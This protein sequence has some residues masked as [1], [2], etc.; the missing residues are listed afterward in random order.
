MCG[1]KYYKGRKNLNKCSETGINVY[2][3]VYAGVKNNLQTCGL[4]CNKSV[5]VGQFW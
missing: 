1:G 4:D 3:C 2:S 5:Y